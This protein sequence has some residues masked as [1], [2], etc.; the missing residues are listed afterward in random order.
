MKRFVLI[1]TACVTWPVTSSWAQLESPNQLGVAM[2]HLHLVVKDVEANKKFFAMFGGTPL[3]VDDTEAMKF[4][5]VLIFLTPGNGG[6][7]FGGSAATHSR[8]ARTVPSPV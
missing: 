5:G 8:S 3:K 1:L 2:G 6:R 7:R 4:P